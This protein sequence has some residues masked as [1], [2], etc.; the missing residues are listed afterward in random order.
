MLC[1]DFHCTALPPLLSLQGGSTCYDHVWKPFTFSA[2]ITTLHFVSQLVTKL[3]A[4]SSYSMVIGFCGQ[5][6]QKVTRPIHTCTSF[7]LLQ[8]LLYTTISMTCTRRPHF[9]FCSPDH[10]FCRSYLHLSPSFLQHNKKT[11]IDIL[12]VY[13][14]LL[15]RLPLFTLAVLLTQIYP[16]LMPTR[17]AASIPCDPQQKI[18]TTNN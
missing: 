8:G 11:A 7:L 13:L 3:M 2:T 9:G 10:T 1:I 14:S 16:T 6:K 17:C 12:Q 5:L 15:P 18:L 4:K